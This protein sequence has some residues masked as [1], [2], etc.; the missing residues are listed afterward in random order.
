MAVPISIVLIAVSTILIPQIG[1][2]ILLINIVWSA[3]RALALVAVVLGLAIINPIFAEESRER[4]M[5]IIINLMIVFF[6]NIGFE[7]GLSRVGLSFEKILP[8]IDT[9]TAGVFDHLLLTVVFALVG[10]FLLYIGI[11]KL[12]R[13]E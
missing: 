7:I 5:G 3:L 8:N 2:E 12:D 10:I 11:R 1:L 6:A 4:N 9:F 13:I